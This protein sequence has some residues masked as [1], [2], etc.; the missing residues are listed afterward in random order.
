MRG[1][2][3]AKEK[4]VHD[5]SPKLRT[6]RPKPHVY[7]ASIQLRRDYTSSILC[8]TTAKTVWLSLLYNTSSTSR[9]ISLENVAGLSRVG[10]RQEASYKV[11][12]ENELYCKQHLDLSLPSVVCNANWLSG[13]PLIASMI[14]ISP[15]FGHGMLVPSIQN[16]G[17]TCVE[18]SISEK[19]D[20]N[21]QDIRNNH[22]ECERRQ[23]LRDCQWDMHPWW[24]SWPRRTL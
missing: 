7:S 21:R 2:L 17:Q 14:S 4:W 9:T 20:K 22:M 3:H 24:W 19:L 16:D 8:K 12:W 23:L 18:R 5:T 15:Q 11:K 13:R 6:H 1:C 10:R